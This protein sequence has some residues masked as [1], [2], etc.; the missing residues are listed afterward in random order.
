MEIIVKQSFKHVN[1]SLPNWDTPGGRKV[2]SEAHY[3]QLLKENNMISYEQAQEQAQKNAK[4]RDY[5]LSGTAQEIINDV[6]S[7]CKD[8][9]N[10]QLKDKPKLVEKMIKHGVIKDNSQYLKYLPSAY[11]PKGGYSNV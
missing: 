2:K 3:K 4:G 8:K 11:Q 6:K 5:K 9:N 1:R 7:H 10:L